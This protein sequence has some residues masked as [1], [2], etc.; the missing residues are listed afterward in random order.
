MQGGTDGH[1]D[2][3]AITNILGFRMDNQSAVSSEEFGKKS[4][5]IQSGGIICDPDNLRFWVTEYIKQCPNLDSWLQLNG[6]DRT[7]YLDKCAQSGQYA[8]S[9]QWEAAQK[10]LEKYLLF[11]RDDDQKNQTAKMKFITGSGSK[12]SHSSKAVMFDRELK[13]YLPVFP[14][15]PTNVLTLAL[16]HFS[17]DSLCLPIRDNF[18]N[19]WIAVVPRSKNGNPVGDCLFL[20]LAL[21]ETL[22]ALVMEASYKKPDQ[23]QTVHPE[24]MPYGLA[25]DNQNCHMALALGALTVLVGP[26]VSLADSADP[27]RAADLVSV[28]HK[29]KESPLSAKELVTVRELISYVHRNVGLQ[30]DFGETLIFLYG[31][32]NSKQ[33]EVEFRQ[34]FTCYTCSKTWD[35][36]QWTTNLNHLQLPLVEVREFQELVTDW[37][38]HENLVDYQCCQRDKSSVGTRTNLVALP[39]VI[40]FTLGR[41]IL[42]RNRVRILLEQ[43]FQ[44][45]DITE[46]KLSYEVVQ[47]GFHE[48]GLYGHFTF[49]MKNLSTGEWFFYDGGIIKKEDFTIVLKRSA[50]IVYVAGK[51][52]SLA[53]AKKV[54]PSLALPIGLQKLPDETSLI[55]PV[56][57]LTPMNEIKSK[58]DPKLAIDDGLVDLMNCTATHPLVKHPM[59]ALMVFARLLKQFLLYNNQAL[60]V[61]L[62]AWWGDITNRFV[63]L[64]Q[65]GLEDPKMIATWLPTVPVMFPGVNIQTYV[66]IDKTVVK[67]TVYS[68][69][70]SKERRTLQLIQLKPDGPYFPMVV[71]KKKATLPQNCL[72]VTRE[73]TKEIM[74]LVTP[75]LT[76]R[77][78]TLGSL[79]FLEAYCRKETND[80][81]G[82]LP[83]AEPESFTPQRIPCP[84]T[85]VPGISE[86]Y[87]LCRMLLSRVCNERSLLF[88]NGEESTSIEQNLSN[89]FALIRMAEIFFDIK[90]DHFH[91]VL[92]CGRGRAL[93]LL[94][95]IAMCDLTVLGIERNAET[96]KECYRMLW[97]IQRNSK[98][99]QNEGFPNSSQVCPWTRP[100]MTAF[101]CDST[102]ITSLAGVTSASRFVG[103]KKKD[104]EVTEEFKRVSKLLLGEK[105]LLFFWC[106]ALREQAVNKLEMDTSKWKLITMEN[107]TEEGSKFSATLFI[108][109]NQVH[110]PV[111]PV[112]NKT[113][114]AAVLREHFKAAQLRPDG[115]GPSPKKPLKDTLRHEPKPTVFFSPAQIESRPRDDSRRNLTAE[116]SGESVARVEG[117]FVSPEPRKKKPRDKNTGE[118]LTS[119]ENKKNKKREISTKSSDSQSP[120]PRTKR[121]KRQAD[122]PA[123]GLNE[124]DFPSYETFH[125]VTPDGKPGQLPGFAP[126][127]AD[128]PGNSPS[129]A[130]TPGNRLPA[131]TPAG[132]PPYRTPFAADTSSGVQ[133]QIQDLREQLKSHVDKQVSGSSSDVMRTFK[134]QIQ[135]LQ[136]VLE[137]NSLLISAGRSQ[138]SVDL[139]D[140]KKQLESIQETLVKKKNNDFLDLLKTV[141]TKEDVKSGVD[142]ARIAGLQGAV[143]DLRVDNV[144]VMLA[145]KEGRE[146]RALLGELMKKMVEKDNSHKTFLPQPLVVPPSAESNLGQPRSHVRVS[147]SMSRSRSKGRRHKKSRGS[148]SRSS[149]RRS[150]AARRSRDS[151]SR[152]RSRGRGRDKNRR[153]RDSRSRSRSEGRGRDKSRRKSHSSSRNSRFARRSLDGC[154]SLSRSR[155]RDQG[156]SQTRNHQRHR[157]S[158]PSQR[159]YERTYDQSQRSRESP[160]NQG[161][162]SRGIP[163]RSYS[164]GFHPVTGAPLNDWS[165]ADVS[166][167]LQERH[168]PNTVVAAFTEAQ[169]SGAMLSTL[170]ND[171]LQNRLKME[172]AH[173]SAFRLAMQCA[174]NR[175]RSS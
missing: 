95:C 151:R 38:F 161:R 16:R 135:E 7:I 26:E 162:S 126:S 145:V 92:G 19:P 166:A 96:V 154:E 69:P 147:R 114:M 62:D 131:F 109:M 46:A 41:N 127:P 97:D 15:S 121:Q 2:L 138:G 130:D 9:F 112:V 137:S 20:A 136:K 22:A 47:I 80:Q 24:G 104:K 67:S 167:F 119:P 160:G 153:S 72:L 44:V 98:E 155:S 150:R 117:P 60:Q 61:P 82:V 172:E 78:T 173:I 124:Q 35:S 94:P 18:D 133:N 51:K 65:L 103:G 77:F 85:P 48:G 139:V 90:E 4:V 111:N 122:S 57:D 55:A 93:L 30:Q 8:D 169:I 158:S 59:F 105:G 25:Y 113:R 12:F 143:A 132:E 53:F 14:D 29:L 70:G 73:D 81:V 174:M 159:R 32:V 101:Q 128:T 56:S 74:F 86:N 21:T 125:D 34:C 50:D 118:S 168:M 148:Q 107:M 108:N 5:A 175:N 37:C 71:P 84:K 164:N 54:M 110:N 13:H 17:P 89:Y 43:M 52:P 141:A 102:A 27:E 36:E 45:V 40:A 83:I 144:Q 87:W 152:S 42:R 68:C 33:S 165:C 11:Y 134:F 1:I 6:K 146:D 3:S 75:P 39:D 149:S 142:Q 88:R 157:S 140:M 23:L 49:L 76:N 120:G 106:Y 171:Y 91:L 79:L 66:T 156:R 163:A 28:L 170:S 63:R 100:K 64:S 31:L 99:I 115:V 123:G 116:L 10:I 58:S 129:P